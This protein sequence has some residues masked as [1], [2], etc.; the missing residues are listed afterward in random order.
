MKRFSRIL[1]VLSVL[2][3]FFLI[4][5][6]VAA[7][8]KPT[9]NVVFFLPDEVYNDLTENEEVNLELSRQSAALVEYYEITSQL[10]EDQLG[11]AFFDDSGILHVLVTND[12]AIISESDN[13]CY[14]LAVY[15]YAQL[16][17]F[18]KKIID[19]R[20]NIGFDACGIDQEDNKVVIYSANS[21]DMDLLYEII[22]NDSVKIIKDDQVMIN[23]ATETVV[24]GSKINDTTS[25]HYGSVSCGVVWDNSTSSKKYGFMTAGHLGEVGDNMS[26][27]GTAMGTMTVK[28]ESGSVDAALIERGQNN[29]YFKFS[30]TVYDGKVFD[31]NGGPF[32]KNTVIYAYGA[33]TTY[34]D[35]K[36][37]T[38]KITDTSFSGTFDN[39]Y[40]TG[41]IK[42]DGTSQNGDSGGPVIT[43]YSDNYAIIGIIKGT[44][45]GNMVYVNMQ[46]IK[47]AFDLNV[48]NP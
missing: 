26:Y 43:S 36:V 28:Q 41:L 46:E 38:G 44:S 7:D 31:Y 19:Q 18:Q 35:G 42:T 37:I 1:S 27:N 9:E 17:D 24:P 4:S 14:E 23:C 32:P 22:P 13:I 40:F 47:T 10:K 11:G 33:T 20:E 48:M 15:S 45:N 12:I 6:T 5:T 3:L 16:E 2:I 30:N 39:I 8:T 34:V 25:G 21:L 29:N